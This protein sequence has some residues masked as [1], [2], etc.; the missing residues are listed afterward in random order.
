MPVPGQYTRA[1]YELK[2]RLHDRLALIR[3][4]Q[5]REPLLARLDARA[6]KTYE[7]WYG[8]LDKQNLAFTRLDTYTLR[9]AMLLA[10]CEGEIEPGRGRDKAHVLITEEVMDAVLA[11]A[12]WQKAVRTQFWPDVADTREARVALMILRALKAEPNGLLQREVYRRVHAERLGNSVFEQA[13]EGLIKG[14]QVAPDTANAGDR[15][16]RPARRLRYVWGLE[17]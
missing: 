12:E 17:R 11:L 7:H 6:K 4:E 16:G 14:G 9:I 13:M 1:Y 2:R 8:T 5:R 10:V 15:G 3:D